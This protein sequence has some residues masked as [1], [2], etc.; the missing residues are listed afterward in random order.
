MRHTLLLCL[1]LIGLAGCSEAVSTPA[2]SAGAVPAVK[3]DFA[4]GGTS[5][6]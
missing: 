3:T 4:N 5:H 6:A 1:A 2:P